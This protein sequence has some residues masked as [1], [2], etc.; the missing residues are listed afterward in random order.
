MVL[1]AGWILGLQ[2]LA[3][4]PIAPF[5]APQAKPGAME[6]L[7]RD[8]HG[9]PVEGAQVNLYVQGPS[10]S[11]M[12]SGRTNAKGETTVTAPWVVNNPTMYDSLTIFAWSEGHAATT[13]ERDIDRLLEGGHREVVTLKPGEELAFRLLMPDGTPAPDE[14]LITLTERDRVGRMGH[15]QRQRK[16]VGAEDGL[17]RFVVTPDLENYTVKVDDAKHYKGWSK[18]FKSTDEVPEFQLP[19]PGRMVVTLD[20]DEEGPAFINVMNYTEMVHSAGSTTRFGN[21]LGTVDGEGREIVFELENLAPGE[22]DVTAGTGSSQNRYGGPT[23]PRYARKSKAEVKSG[24]T[25]T[26]EF[27]E[28]DYDM[29]I[30]EGKETLEAQLI[31]GTG[32]AAGVAWELHGPHRDVIHH[33]QR[34]LVRTGVTGADGVIRIENFNPTPSNNYGRSFQFRLADGTLLGEVNPV[35]YMNRKLERFEFVVPARL[36]EPVADAPVTRMADGR[37]ISLSEHDGRI[38]AILLWS[39]NSDSRTG[40]SMDYVDEW[41]IIATREKARWG[42]DV[43]LVALNIDHALQIGWRVVNERRWNSLEHWWTETPQT[44]LR[45]DVA[46]ALGADQVPWVVMLDEHRRIVTSGSPEDV[47]VE[48][49][50]RKLLED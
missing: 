13:V 39:A 43:V 32:P 26:V 5:V 42:D 12:T 29:S 28:G 50:V 19:E 25:T 8:E 14:L 41:D 20:L 16:P 31:D 9:K 15:N 36:G 37:Q 34:V 38:V 33:E 45:S 1:F 40:N 27:R 18:V 49:E 24:E 4:P 44:G 17:F 10:A 11:G 21:D 48:E 2:L 47:D 30:Y 22:Y 46:R 35:H 3:M 6:L 23:P 7:V